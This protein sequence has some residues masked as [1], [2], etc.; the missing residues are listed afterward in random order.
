M[1]VD[2]AGPHGR[3]VKVDYPADITPWAL[4]TLAE[5]FARSDLGETWFIDP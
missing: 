1:C 2:S 5:L 4:I 3:S